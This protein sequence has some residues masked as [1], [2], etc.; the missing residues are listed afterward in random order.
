MRRCVVSRRM[1]RCVFLLALAAS[2]A[3][4]ASTPIS[5]AIVRDV[6]HSGSNWI[7]NILAETGFATTFQFDGLCLNTSEYAAV[8][9]A[10]RANRTLAALLAHFAAPPKCATL[11]AIEAVH[12]NLVTRDRC[13]NRPICAD[14]RGDSCAAL[15]QYAPLR[16]TALVGGFRIDA[17]PA[18]AP[19]L[20][21][22]GVKLV[23]WIRD[24]VVK[25]S[26]SIMKNSRC[27]SAFNNNHVYASCE[28]RAE[29]CR[30]ANGTAVASRVIWA[31]PAVALADAYRLDHKRRQF[32]AGV[33]GQPFA[34]VAHYEDWQLDR[35]A[36]MRALLAAVGADFA[37]GAVGRADGIV[38]LTPEPVSAYVAN[39]D[40]VDAAFANRSACLRA[41]LNAELPRR[42]DACPED[43]T[44]ET[45]PKK[46]ARKDV[47]GLRCSRADASGVCAAALAKTGGA[48][49]WVC[50]LASS[51]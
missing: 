5:L 7:A 35:A 3:R 32:E 9:P 21:A 39:F 49:A 38:K 45:V 11:E 34:L 16:G 51:F 42:F 2:R 43:P 25:H 17:V 31:D 15:P 8:A 48:D 28:D 29:G 50:R 40:A 13:A 10:A 33:V 23:A 22:A 36:S 26:L 41:M 47:A 20:V 14:A 44:V 24:N 6:G 46:A 18:F 19:P 37:V 27:P 30:E 4:V 12:C 1:R